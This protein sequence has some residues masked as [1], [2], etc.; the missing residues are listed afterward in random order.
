MVSKVIALMACLFSFVSA[1][2]LEISLL[3]S[4][5]FPFCALLLCV[6][7]KYNCATTFLTNPPKS[8]P[9]LMVSGKV[10]SSCGSIFYGQEASVFKFTTPFFQ[11]V[12]CFYKIWNFLDFWRLPYHI[13]GPILK[14]CCEF[15]DFGP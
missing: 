4:N 14:F 1:W 15:G 7:Y 5:S 8:S 3:W 10:T 6:Y 11:V 9:F 2:T 13:L 12:M